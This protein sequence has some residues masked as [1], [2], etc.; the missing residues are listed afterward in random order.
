MSATALSEE[1]KAIAEA[2]PLVSA[3]KWESLRRPFPA[4][5]VGQLPKAGVTLDYV[6]H[7]AVTR[8][9][10]E[11]DP[12]WSWEP[13]ALGADGLP[14]FTVDREGNLIAFWIRLTILGRT[15]PGCGTCKAGQFD[16]EK[17]LIGDAIRNAAMRFGVALDLWIRG[18]A[19]DDEKVSGANTGAAPDRSATVAAVPAQEAKKALLAALDGDTDA[20]TQAWDDAGLRG[21]KYVPQD[22]LDALLESIAPFEEAS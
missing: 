4:D 2:L 5:Q 7:G 15:K 16:A 22:Q 14:K 11:V 10:L 17:V 1:A 8:R 12:D 9:L 18:H 20:A 19:E 3:E 6:G 21:S 13:F